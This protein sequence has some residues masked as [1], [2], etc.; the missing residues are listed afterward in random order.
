MASS[1]SKAVDSLGVDT[2]ID[3]SALG[4]SDM[5]HSAGAGVIGSFLTT[6]NMSRFNKFPLSSGGETSAEV[7]YCSAE[8]PWGHSGMNGATLESHGQHNHFFMLHHPIIL[9]SLEVL[10]GKVVL[11]P[12]Q[13][14]EGGGPW[15]VFSLLCGWHPEGHS[16]PL[17][18]P[19]DLD[20]AEVL[21]L[22]V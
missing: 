22:G 21:I 19:F 14:Q 4:L 8:H 5:A 7:L 2:L 6:C 17:G 10:L 11:S 13:F 1:G 12:Q 18:H 3:S 16:I 9:D 20:I 15:A